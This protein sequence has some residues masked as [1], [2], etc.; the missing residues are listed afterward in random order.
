MLANHV[1]GAV[2]MVELKGGPHTLGFNG[3]LEFLLNNLLAKFA[4]G[5]GFPVQTAWNT[6]QN[7]RTH[8]LGVGLPS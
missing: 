8:L 5:M 4:L 6:L 1:K 3:I 7:S 2:R